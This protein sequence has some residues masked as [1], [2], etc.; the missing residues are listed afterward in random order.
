MNSQDVVI[1]LR[2]EPIRLN[3]ILSVPDKASKII[4][5][6]HGSGS[7]RLSPRNQ[8]VA[9]VLNQEGIATL[10]LDLLTPEEELI[11]TST[12][13]YRF[14]IPLLA[15]RLIGTCNWIKK[16]IA[17]QSFKIGFFG[18]STGSAAALIAAKKLGN[19]VFA[20]VSRGGRPDLALDAL[21]DVTAPVLL[22]VGG[23]DFGVIELNE[24]AFQALRRE[25]ELKIIPGATHL[26]EEEGTLEQA[27]SSAAKWFKE[28]NATPHTIL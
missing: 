6:A 28:H 9:S 24:T 15:K 22:I 4:V 13:S 5:F 8:Y 10:L 1:D 2:P 14:D 12:R 3:G 18:A 20:V 23:N 11:D 7:G 25:K 27:A 21:P 16:N 19:T 17:L 26:F